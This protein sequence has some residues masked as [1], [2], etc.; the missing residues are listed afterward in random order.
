MKTALV[1]GASKGIGRQI[2]LTLSQN[3]YTVIGTYN[4][5][6]KNEVE[7]NIVYRKC[8]VADYAEVAELFAYIKENYKTLDAV[9]NC[10]GVSWV[11]LLQD[12][13][14]E[15]ISKLVS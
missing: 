7:E 13:K 12:M 14:E 5:T 4:S 6:I 1:T 10:A 2:A 11:G 15:E 9:V 8:N 3:G